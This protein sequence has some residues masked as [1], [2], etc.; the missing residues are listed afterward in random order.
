MVRQL[1]PIDNTTNG[2]PVIADKMGQES[3]FVIL[4]PL[5]SQYNLTFNSTYLIPLLP[6]PPTHYIMDLATLP[7]TPTQIYTPNQVP[8]VRF[9]KSSPTKLMQVHF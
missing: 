4:Y 1:Q 5:T 3:S 6:T 9:L 2:K 7:P 8:S